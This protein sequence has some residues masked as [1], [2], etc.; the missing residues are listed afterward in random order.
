MIRSRVTLLMILLV[1]FIT[2][3]ASDTIVLA[4]DQPTVTHVIPGGQSVGV[5]LHT[6]GV[7][8]AGFSE[9]ETAD[10]KVSPAKQSGLQVGDIIIRVNQ[11][12]I[13]NM[14]E[15]T[16]LLERMTKK[17][18]TVELMIKRKENIFPVNLKPYEIDDELKLGLFIKDATAGIGTMTFY[19]PTF[20]KY[21]ALGHRITDQHSKKPMDIYNGKIVQSQVTSINKGE[22]G[23]PG[24]KKARFSMKDKSLG[25]IQKNSDY[26]IFG[27]VTKGAELFSEKEPI[28][29]ASSDEVK[30]GKAKIYTV[31]EGDEVESFDVEI[32]SSK[33]SKKAATKGMI[34]KV[35]DER[36]LK[37]TGGIVQGMSGSPIIQDG[38][39]VGAVTHVFL[40][41]SKSGYGVHV[42]WMLNEAGL[43][44]ANK[45]TA[46]AS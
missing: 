36:L 17:S 20:Q 24:E 45:Q 2:P 9:I 35:T 11:A 46:L 14:S 33:P 41:D 30:K 4:E 10:G 26:G 16:S 43:Q 5:Q 38:K 1:S 7:V 32:V 21:G 12:K 42:E 13:E 25:T 18:D 40:N 37:E 23:V 31:V 39:L 22:N 15:F 44:I 8:V 27:K 3:F 28:P 29:V 6:A 34:I 19:D